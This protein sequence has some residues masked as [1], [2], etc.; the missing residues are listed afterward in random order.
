MIIPAINAP[1]AIVK[2]ISWEAQPV[3]RIIKTTDKVRC[4]LL[5]ILAIQAKPFGTTS[6]DRK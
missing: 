4:S 6:L 5:P 1:M 2:P 3:T